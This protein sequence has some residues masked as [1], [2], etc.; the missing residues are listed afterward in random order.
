MAAFKS[1]QHRWAKGSIQTARKLLGDVLRSDLP[2]AVKLEALF[3]LTANAAYLLMALL[4]VLMPLTLFVRVDRG[5]AGS[6]AM[7]LPLFL[8]A[9]VAVCNFYALSQRELGRGLLEQIRNLPMVLALGIGMSLNNGRAV[10]E[11]LIGHKSGFVRTPKYDV[12]GRKDRW[13]GKNYVHFKWIQPILELALGLW[14][15]PAILFAIEHGG[16]SLLTLPFLVLFQFGYLYVS[17]L[18]IGQ[19]LLG[20]RARRV[21]TS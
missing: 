14:F 1:Q 17:L 19:I 20:L 8:L 11:A 10:L 18:S 3:Q 7:D 6:L 2:R 4:S 9:T 15:T 5:W 21:A 12:R 16:R 13:H